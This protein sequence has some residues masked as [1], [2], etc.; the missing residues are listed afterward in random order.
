MQYEP[1]VYAIIVIILGGGF[2]MNKEPISTHDSDTQSKQQKLF[3]MLGL[4][5]SKVLGENTYAKSSIYSERIARGLT[6]VFTPPVAAK[7]LAC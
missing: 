3:S 4:M 1:L 2:E 7:Y 6:I 5:T